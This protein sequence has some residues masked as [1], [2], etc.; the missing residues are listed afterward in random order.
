MIIDKN[1]KNM[2]RLEN[3]NY[4]IEGD[5]I[6]DED[7]KIKLDNWFEVQGLINV[8]GSIISNATIKAG[9]GIKAGLSITAKW[10]S[11]K[12]RIF[13]GIC[14]WRKIDESD[15]TITCLELKEGEIA[16]GKLNIIKPIKKNK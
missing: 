16:F 9:Y 11:S 12:L 15:M 3:G 7:L 8:Q 10:I 4:F 1:Y 14:N 2:K 6:V 13:A 5:L